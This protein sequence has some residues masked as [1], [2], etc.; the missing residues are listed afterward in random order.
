VGGSEESVVFL[1]TK[2][3]WGGLMAV[4]GRAECRVM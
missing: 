4:R 3:S 1:W 2:G